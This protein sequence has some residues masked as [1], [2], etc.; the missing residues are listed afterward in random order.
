MK[1]GYSII[2]KDQPCTICGKMMKAPRG[3]VARHNKGFAHIK[4][5][6]D[7]AREKR[8]VL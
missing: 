2:K 8:N 3:G 7:K 4:C 1:C 5:I 6:M